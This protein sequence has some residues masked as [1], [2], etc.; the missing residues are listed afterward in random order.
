MKK[1]FLS[2]LTAMVMLFMTLPYMPA[3]AEETGAAGYY[4]SRPAFTNSADGTSVQL[5]WR[6][7]EVASS[8]VSLYNITDSENPVKIGDT[9]STAANEAVR[10]TVSGLTV[11]AQYLFKV[12]CDFDGHT[13]TSLVIGGKASAHVTADKPISGTSWNIEEGEKSLVSANI[14]TDVKASG[15]ASLHI[16]N[17]GFG[18]AGSS[19]VDC[20]QLRFPFDGYQEGTTY[21][22]KMKVKGAHFK[23][24]WDANGDVLGSGFNGWL[25]GKENGAYDPFDFDWQEISYEF[26][27]TG[28]TWGM[29]RFRLSAMQAKD[30][31][32]DDITFREKGSDT[33]I[34]IGGGFEN[35]EPAAAASAIANVTDNIANISITAPADSKQVYIYEEIENADILRA[36]L[37]SSVTSLKLENVTGKLKIA[38]K[39][40]GFVMSEKT[41]IQQPLESD[42]NGSAAKFSPISA[43]GT[44][45]KLSWKNPEVECSKVSLYDVT[46]SSNERLIADNYS[47]ETGAAVNAIVDN[48]TVGQNYTYKV[49]FEFSSHA[50]T[51]LTITGAAREFTEGLY[52]SNPTFN[53][54]SADGT[55]M[56]ISWQNPEIECSKVSLYNVTDS[57][58]ETLVADNYSTEAG[59]PVSAVVNGLT[60]G[61]KYFYKVK[62][63][64]ADADPT[65]LM[66]GG[67]AEEFVAKEVGTKI[68]G[69]DWTVHIDGA[70]NNAVSA[71]IDTEVTSS[72]SS[73]ASLHIVNNSTETGNTVLRAKFE[74]DVE[75][76]ETYVFSFKVKANRYTPKMDL[77]STFFAVPWNGYVMDKADGP[78]D[79]DWVTLS[80]EI[81]ATA[82]N[83]GW[84]M[85]QILLPKNTA[86]D[87]WIDDI[88]VCKKGTPENLVTGGDF[89]NYTSAQEPS[90]IAIVS[91]DT[92]ELSITPPADGK[93]IYVYEEVN[94]TDVLRGMFDASVT[95]VKL[96]GVKGKLKLAS[97]S[98]GFVMSAKGEVT[99]PGETD[100]YGYAPTFS[101]ADK[102]EGKKAEISWRNPN[103][104]C[105]KVSVYDITN[106]R[107]VKLIADNYSTAAEEAV[108]TVIEGLAVGQDYTYKV[109]FDFAD[110][111]ST[112]L[113]IGGTVEKFE[114]GMSPISGSGWNVHKE[115][116][117][118]NAVSINVDTTVKASG[119]ASL[120]ISNNSSLYGNTM[121][122]APYTG[123][124]EPGT[125][126]VLSM[127]VKADKY[128]PR[129][130]LLGTV[131]AGAWNGWVLDRQD[132]PFG[133]DWMTLTKEYTPET[134]GEWAMI[135]VLLP[136]MTAKDMWI[137]D[138]TLC[139]KD[140]SNN[141]IDGG[142]FESYIDSMDVT[143]AKATAEEDGSVTIGYT[144]PSG[145]KA[146]YVYQKVGDKLIQR[147]N[148]A[149]HN[150]VNI[151]GLQQGAENEFVIKT[152]SDG[153]VLSEGITVKANAEVPKY[154][155]GEYKL[156]KGDTQITAPEPGSAMTVKL[157]VENV[158][159]GDDFTVCYIVAVYDGDSMI[160]CEV[161]DDVNIKNNE[162][163]T[164]SASV[165]YGTSVE[166]CKIRAFL[167]KDFENMGILKISGEF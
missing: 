63:E 105:S 85:M 28:P 142:D 8:K 76:G 141:L 100:Y 108:T 1:R 101:S 91:N 110:H 50:N 14:D 78:F 83:T 164:L 106:P 13:S 158:E 71:N 123:A 113:I 92:T 30:M 61:Q 134:A 37:D 21:V 44:K 75:I 109:V 80:K 143:D 111:E 135:Q 126:Y 165:A 35:F 60:K 131:F 99:Q 118:N 49:V 125:T 57:G 43:N 120:H 62:F 18:G 138:I 147:T 48:L 69:S 24:L 95:S 54:A 167:W 73:K 156:Y 157:D 146:V 7:P 68:S 121:L 56:T 34:A 36:V 33:D 31:W 89:E 87:M 15:N 17:N 93:Q 119:N 38:S 77:M 162:T 29:V 42:Y 59:A 139:K 155:T 53:V 90:A 107:N 122:R 150:K 10:E 52:G 163:K 153:Y 3:L 88:M 39:S 9:Y 64:F 2:M 132:G 137:D 154:R 11:G 46:D 98:A 4:A 23:Q 115:D 114:A 96:S 117:P 45:A 152:L 82:D 148:V 124:I 5:S 70:D 140:S 47:R 144:I 12:V 81:V 103:V 160:D 159:M 51:E 127:K 40:V 145:T 161:V 130:D 67:T 6:N 55:A 94:G 166:N 128:I 20:V 16:T 74:R 112:S 116:C 27:P 104:A 19:E 86:K 136:R 129:S 151:D 22:L 32:I 58:N 25:F 66:I 79:F 84:R 133:F 149:S 97:K 26:A 102:E 41:E 72:K 65:S